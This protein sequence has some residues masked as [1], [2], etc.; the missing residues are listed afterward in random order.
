MAI[1]FLAVLD[2]LLLFCINMFE[3][4]VSVNNIL[5]TSI[6]LQVYNSMINREKINRI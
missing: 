2:I 5:L 6:L 3:P 1:D 4:T